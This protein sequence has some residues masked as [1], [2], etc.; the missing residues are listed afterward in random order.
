V[1]VINSLDE[2]NRFRGAQF[3][4]KRDNGQADSHGFSYMLLRKMYQDM[5]QKMAFDQEIQV[6][7]LVGKLK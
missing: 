3:N 1:Y 7:T 4:I 2:Q 5:G 6:G